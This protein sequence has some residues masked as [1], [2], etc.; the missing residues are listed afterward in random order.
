MA[1]GGH[2]PSSPTWQPNTGPPPQPGPYPG[3][4]PPPGYL[5]QGPYL[6]PPTLRQR[7]REDDWPT[8]TEVLRRIRLHGCVWA[9]LLCCLWQVFL[10]VLAYP[11]ARTARSQARRRFPSHPHHRLLDADVLHLQKARAWVALIA[12]AALLIVYDA[13]ADPGEVLEQYVF[14]LAVTPWLLLL[15]APLVVLILLR[16]VPAAARPGMRT[17]LRPTV[18]TALLYVAAFTVVPTLTVGLVFL[19]ERA[20]ETNADDRTRLIALGGALV[21]IV[22][23]IWTLFFVVFASTTVVRSAFGIGEVH[24]AL[25]ALLT[26]VLVWELAAFSLTVAGMPPGPPAVRIGALLGGPLSVSALAWWEISRLRSRYGVT[27][28]G[29]GM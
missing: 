7:F 20:Q 14:R 3:P 22:P 9:L 8:L 6:P 4:Y 28:R 2:D 12:S 11:L 13:E 21:L 17:R 23:V 26:G 24:L 10:P 18:R 1:F 27:L 5:P 15:T 29:T 25:P 16:V 19:A